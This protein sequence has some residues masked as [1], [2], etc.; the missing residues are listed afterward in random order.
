MLEDPSE[1]LDYTMEAWFVGVFMAVDRKQAAH[2]LR[3]IAQLAEVHGENVHR[4]RAYANAA[5]AVERFEGDL[6]ANVI[7]KA[8]I[9]MADWVADW[10]NLL[11]FSCIG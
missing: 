10:F 3:H 4:V 1:I 9:W 5:R 6:A 11:F 8:A 2:L 7:R